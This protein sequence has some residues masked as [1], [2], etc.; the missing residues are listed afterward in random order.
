MTPA[1]QKQFGAL[2]D[3][4][5]RK[6]YDFIY[7]KT[8]H[9]E[10]AEDLASQTFLKA[11]ENFVNFNPDKGTFS[12]WLYKIARNTVIDYYRTHKVEANIEDVF[13][14]S[15][16]ND[17]LGDFDR[18]ENLQKVKNYLSK[19]SSEQREIIVMRVWQEM[20]YEEIAEVLGKSQESCRMMF[21]RTLS[22]LKQE[23]PLTLFILFLIK[24][25]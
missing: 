1:E 10:T 5:I 18:K 2:Y 15:Q 8:Y 20:S 12:A 3:K 14:L 13:D 16:E 11:A 23:M 21:S 24:S 9:K 6:I 7:F 17:V 4:H 19:L 22:K 25:I